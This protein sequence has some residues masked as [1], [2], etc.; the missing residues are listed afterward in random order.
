MATAAV[1]SAAVSIRIITAD[2]Y[3]TYPQTLLDHVPQQFVTP[4]TKGFKVPVVRIFGVT[5]LGQKACVHLHDDYIRNFGE[6]LNL[7][8]GI[9]LEKTR[10]EIKKALYIVSVELVKGVPFYG[11]HPQYAP[12]LKISYSSPYQTSKIVQCL[13]RGS[14]M[15][16]AFQP[17][18]AHL[19]YL[20][21]LF[22][23]YNLYGMDFLDLHDARFRMPIN[24][25]QCTREWQQELTSL[26]Q[27]HF[28]IKRSSGSKRRAARATTPMQICRNGCNGHPAIGCND[29]AT[30]SWS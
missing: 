28:S 12:F 11:F 17:H 15:N 30:A 21:Q 2:H 14:I 19:A 27:A 20:H 13:E 1:D 22:I 18:E 6:S 26:I 8:V 4:L 9:L 23:D 24:G 29:R 7:A 16:T 25:M 5:A 3:Q 10:E